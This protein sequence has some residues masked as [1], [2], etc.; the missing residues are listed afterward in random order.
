VKK[1]ITI[2][3]YWGG[4]PTSL[5]SKGQRF[6]AVIE[7]CQQKGWR[8]FLLCAKIPEDHTLVDPFREIGCEIIMQRR[9]R[10][11]FDVAS[12]WRKYRLL[13]RLKCD[14]FH[15]DNDHTSP[16][17]GAVLARVPIRIWSQ[18]SMSPY[19]EKGISPK[20]L[21]RLAVSTRLSCLCAGRVLAISNQV[22]QELVD[23][24]GFS[25][26]ID[27]VHVPVD[28]S[29]F[30]NAAPGEIRRELGLL[31]S[32]TL[33]TSVGHAIPVK[34]WD[35]A[36][37][38]F[39]E[40]QKRFPRAHLLF[41][42][43]TRSPQEKKFFPKLN[44]LVKD[45]NASENIH[46]IGYRHDTPEILKASDIFILPSRS[47]GLCCALIEAM[48]S[49]LPCIAA[50]VGGIPEVINHGKDG[51][52][53]ER[54][55]AEELSGHLTRLIEDKPLRTRIALQATHTSKAFSMKAYVDKII[56]CYMTLLQKNSDNKGVPGKS[57]LA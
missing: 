36:I 19:Y 40:V 41:A 24:V 54:E 28:H 17:I 3:H 22:R 55:N 31:P 6:L 9:S 25:K 26:R 46:F 11:E 57:A 23:S 4:C 39:I 34:G 33:I 27:T 48:A 20:G 37:R 7:R 35:I 32:D 16:L 2:V 12:I 8:N 53:F 14:I 10:G 5:T 38:S 15:C 18:L 29:R 42:G 44:L 43:G 51:L 47:D 13:R 21:H 56:D 1:S 49:G 45:C 52:L 30:A 50:K